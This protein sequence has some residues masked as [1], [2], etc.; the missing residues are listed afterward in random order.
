[1][2]EWQLRQTL[3]KAHG[4]PMAPGLIQLTT[5]SLSKRD[6]CLTYKDLKLFI[7]TFVHFLC[8]YSHVQS[9]LFLIQSFNLSFL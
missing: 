8:L 5:R 6:D 4:Y 2:K 9:K 3:K 7:L 1:M